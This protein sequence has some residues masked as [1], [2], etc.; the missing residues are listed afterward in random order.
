MILCCI[1]VIW[2]VCLNGLLKSFFL[3]HCS[4]GNKEELDF[5]IVC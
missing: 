1:S 5:S 4:S 2:K 3:F